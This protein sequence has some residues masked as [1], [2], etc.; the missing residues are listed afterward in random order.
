[1]G[2]GGGGGVNR[3]KGLECLFQNCL[4]NR[5]AFTTFIYLTLQY[6]KIPH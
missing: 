1:M 6:I 3:E 4:G 2:G 5:L